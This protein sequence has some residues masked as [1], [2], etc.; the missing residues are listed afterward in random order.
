MTRKCKAEGK[1]EKNLAIIARGYYAGANRYVCVTNGI[2]THAHNYVS[3][4]LQPF[5]RFFPPFASSID[6]FNTEYLNTNFL[7][8]K[9]L[10]MFENLT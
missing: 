6:E 5:Q 3:S 9:I 8:Q 4:Y 7:L 2:H 1:L 10:L